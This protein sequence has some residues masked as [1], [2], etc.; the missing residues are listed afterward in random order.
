MNGYGELPCDMSVGVIGN[1][2]KNP[3]LGFEPHG[4]QEG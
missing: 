4:S 1:S 2:V 3:L